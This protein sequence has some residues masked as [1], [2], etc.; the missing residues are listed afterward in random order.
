MMST[1]YLSEARDDAIVYLSM[2]TGDM[3][4]FLLWQE[5]CVCIYM[6]TPSVLCVFMCMCVYIYLCI[7][8]YICIYIYT[9]IHIYIY[10]HHE[11]VSKIAT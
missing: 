6:Y 4:L 11:W 9:Y 3:M 1:L 7:H 2:A 10:I 8:V 5:V